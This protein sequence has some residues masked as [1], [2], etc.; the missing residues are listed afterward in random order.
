MKAKHLSNVELAVRVANAIH[1]S[2]PD[3]MQLIRN[4]QNDILQ[5]LNGRNIYSTK[6]VA[7]IYESLTQFCDWEIQDAFEF[8]HRCGYTPFQCHIIDENPTLEILPGDYWAIAPKDNQ[9][10]WIGRGSIV[11]G[12]AILATPR[13]WTPSCQVTYTFT[14]YP[15]DEKQIEASIKKETKS[16]LIQPPSNTKKKSRFSFF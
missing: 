4:F 12:W 7:S 1:F 8:C 15:F 10:S 5:Q 3:N 9:A 13:N 2:H 16:E 14:K 6:W 11:D